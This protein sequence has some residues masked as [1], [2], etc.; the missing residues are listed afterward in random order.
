MLGVEK[1]WLPGEFDGWRYN[2]PII[3]SH[4]HVNAPGSPSLGVL[5]K[6]AA[7]MGIS[8]IGA[9]CHGLSWPRA[10]PCKEVSH[11]TLPFLHYVDGP[12]D[13]DR[14]TLAAM[15]AEGARGAK[16]WFAT[17]YFSGLRRI[18]TRGFAGYLRLLGELGFVVVAHIS[19]PDTWHA[20]YYPPGEYGT[21]ED[22]RSQMLWLVQEAP[23]T[24]F[25]L[26]HMG[27]Y[28]ENP[29]NL[30]ASL[31]AHP[32]MYLDTSATKWV[33]R[34]LSRHHDDAVDLFH[35][36]PDRILFGSDIVEP[37]HKPGNMNE[38][39]YYSSRYLVQRLML[40]HRGEFSSPI[41]DPDN[42]GNK[43]LVGLDLPG[44]ILE[45]VYHLNAE[46]IGL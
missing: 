42:V 36:Y 31:D 11:Y 45:R 37:P 39:Q 43:P 13:E 9:I 28:P 19:D 4:V 40:E 44:A 24:T 29:R 30:G 41:K 2:G 14:K 17:R 35:S 25:V 46:S 6:V 7:S 20:K 18:D 21:K 23:G 38:K 8:K 12:S 22:L 15:R 5:C 33:S 10:M 26:V 3:D 16:F 34:E 32:N 27:G 1:N